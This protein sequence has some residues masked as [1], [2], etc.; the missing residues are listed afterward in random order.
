M[1]CIAAGDVCRQAAGTLYTALLDSPNCRIHVSGVWS[2]RALEAKRDVGLLMAKKQFR[3]TTRFSA[4][5]LLILT[6]HVLAH[7]LVLPK[8]EFISLQGQTVCTAPLTANDSDE[9]THTGDFKPPKHSFVDYATFFSPK[10]FIPAYNPSAS[11][12]TAYEPFQA[13]QQVYLKIIV[14]PDSLA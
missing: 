9:Q 2:C 7:S 14:P 1:V 10:H 3:P 8:L 12:L 6:L 4:L 11:R 13:E 5:L